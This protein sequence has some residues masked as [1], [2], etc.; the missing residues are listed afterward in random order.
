MLGAI[1]GDIVGS[2]FERHNHIVNRRGHFSHGL[3]FL[4][5][6]S[7]IFPD[8]NELGNDFPLKLQ[9]FA[10][11]LHDQKNADNSQT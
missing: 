10:N 8:L 7:K 3:P 5:L 11:D 2:R 1:I 9:N 4:L 6:P